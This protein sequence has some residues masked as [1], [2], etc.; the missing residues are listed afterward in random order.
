MKPDKKYWDFA[1]IFGPPSFAPGCIHNAPEQ[2]TG[3]TVYCKIKYTILFYKFCGN[4]KSC[5]H[6]WLKFYTHSILH[7]GENPKTPK[8]WYLKYLKTDMRT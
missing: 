2:R 8:N 5:I 4:S 1:I 3:F 6:L 7:R